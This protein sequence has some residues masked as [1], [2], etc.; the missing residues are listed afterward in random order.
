[1]LAVGHA[2]RKILNF[3]FDGRSH[4]PLKAAEIGQMVPSAVSSRVR[5]VVSISD[6]SPAAST[7]TK[8]NGGLIVCSCIV[9][10]LVKRAGVG[11]VC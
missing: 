7:A 6:T 5:D 2:I 10:P 8:T 4:R 3:K 1:M 11:D 9:I